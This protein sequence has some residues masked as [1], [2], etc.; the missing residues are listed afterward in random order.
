MDSPA[1]LAGM[2]NA[3]DTK[4]GLAMDP[5][6]YRSHV[7]YQTELTDIIF[8]SWLYAGHISELQRNGDYFLFDIGEDSVIVCRDNKGQIRA[9][10][11]ICR[12]RGARVC[13]QARGNRKAFVCPYH[14]WAYNNDGSLKVARD[15]DML[16]GFDAADYPLKSVRLEIF[17]GLI[18]INCDNEAAQFSPFLEPI[19]KPL[20]A[21]DL[22][23]AKVAES[24]T[25]T[26]DANWQ[27]CL[28]NYILNPMI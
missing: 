1:R 2:L 4:P 28:E 25:Y 23:N 5:Y 7:T 11:N 9:H 20:A 22:D 24:K 6:F 26:I 12:H 8:K 27:L 19:A 3:Q 18:F 14:G 17:Q 13:E 15:M 21:Y 16:E 10:H